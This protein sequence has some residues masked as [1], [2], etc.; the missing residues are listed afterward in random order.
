[1]LRGVRVVD[2][3]RFMPGPFA[4][5]RLADLGAEVIKIEPA[6]S[7][8]P[9][10]D[11]D[12]GLP[13][14]A[15]NRRKKSVTINMKEPEGQQL[16]FR[17]ACKADVIMVSFRPGVAES[18][19]IGYEAVKRENPGAIYCA[20]TGYGQ[21][22]P[23]SRLGGHDLNYLALSGILA[24]LK[25]KAGKPVQPSFQ[26]ADMIGGIAAAEAIL[27]AL[28][29]KL[30]YSQGAYLD[31]AMTDTLIGMM[32]VHALIQESMGTGQGIEELKGSIVAYNIY[33]TADGR[34]ISLGAVEDKFWANFCR[35]V[36]R[37]QW[38]GQQTTPA[39]PGNAVFA[40]MVSLFKSKNFAEWERFSREVDCCMTPVMETGDMMHSSY[41]QEKGL[42]N[43]TI[44]WQ[45]PALG[46]HT[47][48]VLQSILDASP[49]QIRDWKERGII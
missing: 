11:K 28:V 41:V 43:D 15:I 8:D 30:L 32:S 33:E 18:M 40:G 19:G 1:M 37:P 45:S 34:F 5:Q 25:D 9:L 14:R 35:A 12:G 29:N 46:Q 16:A 36:D 3:S 38:F 47:E 49:S 21:S 4:S 44:T 23:L 7:G 42:L 31:C 24:Q 10:R 48:E 6:G 39:D 26:F 20:L 13:F 2:F 17:L 27:A 22:G